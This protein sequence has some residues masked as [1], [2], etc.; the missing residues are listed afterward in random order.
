M[1]GQKLFSEYDL[2]NITLK[3]RL[4]MAPMTRARATGNVPN[5]LV[6]EYY[7]QRS[8]AGLIITEGT[9]PSA[10]GL[11]Y[12]RIPGIFNKEQIEGWK[13]V[14]KAV[15]EKGSKIFIQLMHTGRVSHVDNLPEGSEVLS[16]SDKPMSGEM[17]T[18]AKGN[19][20]YTH[21]RKMTVDDIKNT[22]KEHIE[23][24]KNAV[25]AGFDGVELHGANGYLIEQ[26]INPNVNDRT[27]NYGGTHEN[28]SRFL[29]ELAQGV[30]EAIGKDKVGLRLSPYGAFNDTGEF[31][32]IE[33]AYKYIIGEMSGLGIAY[34][35]LVDHSSMGAPQVPA[36]IKEMVRDTF[37]GTL[38]LSGGYDVIRAEDDL[39]ANKGDLVA[40]GRPFIA[41]PNLVEAFQKE[42]VELAQ[43]DFDTFYTPGAKGYT[44]YPDI[45]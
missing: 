9:S 31:D 28:R 34:I 18:D 42:D 40:F 21:P 37:E 7:A 17:Y 19:Q 12:A 45:Q 44:D 13:L 33:E 3:N 22:V 4:V 43:P 5:E 11:G 25:E 32:G 2:G 16:P 26:F 15:H 35:H 29:L 23:A 27:D 8:G 1:N 41:N 36:A 14:T 24:A 38:I 30:S 20:P 10:N 6:A 39:N